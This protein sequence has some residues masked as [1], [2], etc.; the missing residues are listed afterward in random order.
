MGGGHYSRGEEGRDNVRETDT[1]CNTMY[2]YTPCNSIRMKKRD[3]YG[4]IFFIS[5]SS[6]RYVKI[7]YFIT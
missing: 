6:I 3:K 4:N 2:N 5:A 7:Y 1:A